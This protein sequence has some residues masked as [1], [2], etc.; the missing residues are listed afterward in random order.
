MKTIY[1]MEDETTSEILMSYLT[2]AGYSTRVFS[3]TGTLL[4]EIGKNS[5]DMLIMDA[6]YHER[7][8]FGIMREIKQYLPELL[9]IFLTANAAESERILGFELG[10]DDY[11]AKPFR[12]KEVLL[13]IQAVFRRNEGSSRYG[14]SSPVMTF[15]QLGNRMRI[16]MREHLVSINGNEISLTEAEWKILYLLASNANILISRQRLLQ[17]CFEYRTG[18]YE[19]LIDTHIKNLRRKIQPGTW[20][21]TIRSFGY[22]FT[23][24]QIISPEQ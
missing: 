4:G 3:S 9:N 11:I 24:R 14:S 23:A 6:D 21:D 10:C 1:V 8:G 22:R 17:Q 2:L 12:A 5:P 18:C 7:D 20:I 16:S 13:R 19:R 15:E